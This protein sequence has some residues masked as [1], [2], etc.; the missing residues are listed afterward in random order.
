MRT[1]VFVLGFLIAT[2]AISIADARGLTVLHSFCEGDNCSETDNFRTPTLDAGGNLYAVGPAGGAQEQGLIIELSRKA[3]SK[4]WKEKTLHSF[5]SQENCADGSMG[6]GPLSSDAHGNLYGA[7]ENGGNPQERSGVVF[8]L[9]PKAGGGWKY[10]V[11]YSFCSAA[12]CTDGETGDGTLAIDTAGNIYGVAVGGGE[13]ESGVVY[14]LSPKGGSWSEKVLYS[15]CAQASCAD[16]KSPVSGLAYA[17]ASSRAPYAGT[18]PLCGTTLRGD[19]NDEGTV[20]SLTPAG[21]KW[22]EK[23]LYAF[24]PAM[25][26]CPDGATPVTQG[27][28]A[29]DTS[30]NLFGTTYGGGSAASGVVFELS[31]HHRNWVE[32]VLHSF[33]SEAL[34]SDGP[35]AANLTLDATGNLYGSTLSGGANG[36]GEIFK[37]KPN[38]VQSAMSSIYDFCSRPACADGGNP[39]SGV[40]LD[41]DGNLY[42]TTADGG[43]HHDGT[44]FRLMP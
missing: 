19:I 7:T 12:G 21:T 18:S 30:G 3:G 28:I 44:A 39:D 34:C 4:T 22:K 26:S 1:C 13:H 25:D 20:F 10:N 40:I 42:G 29:L 32:A 6:Y 8:E 14:E 35:T 16:G 33:C 15:F 43:A 41:S 11:I 36:Q 37:L 38:G 24:C 23:V 9:T 31:K 17:G 5:C 2:S 27:A